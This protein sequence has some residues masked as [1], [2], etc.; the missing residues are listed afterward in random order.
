MFVTVPKCILFY[1]FTNVT[2]KANLKDQFVLLYPYN[3]TY[4]VTFS[5]HVQGDIM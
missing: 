4:N 5:S 2:F 1:F 3:I